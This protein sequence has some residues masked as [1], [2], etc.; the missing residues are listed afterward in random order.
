MKLIALDIDGTFID[1]T[2]DVSGDYIVYPEVVA[3]LNEWIKK[4]NAIV[5]ASGRPFSGIKQFVDRL[6]FSPYVFSAASNGAVLYRYTGEIMKGFYLPYSVFLAMYKAFSGHKGWTYMCYFKDGVLGYEGNAN[7]APFE[8][9]YNQMSYLDVNSVTIKSDALIQKAF[10]ATDDNSAY[11]LAAP[12]SLRSFCLSYA[13]SPRFF[14]FISRHA[15]KSVMV[16]ELRQK[17]GISTD[18]VYTFGDGEND[19]RMLANYHGTAMGNAIEGCK[20]A[21]EFVTKDASE[22]GIVYATRDYWKLI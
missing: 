19:V 20:K 11:S 10:I 5:F 3:V 12:V 15:D 14:E 13:T 2:F 21:A 7:Y 18:D 16:E 1:D 17:L 9:R 6:A 8:A 4:G 22:R